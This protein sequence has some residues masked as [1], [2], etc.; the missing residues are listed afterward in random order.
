[1]KVNLGTIE[2]GDDIRRAIW[3]WDHGFDYGGNPHQCPKAG[4][5]E[6]KNWYRLYGD[7]MDDDLMGKYQE[8][9]E[10]WDHAHRS[11]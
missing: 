1:M 9:L 10:V 3:W 8:A 2:V 7:T 4:H 6:L 5:K 11:K